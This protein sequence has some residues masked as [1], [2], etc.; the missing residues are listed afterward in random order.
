MRE[1]CAEAIEKI[2]MSTLSGKCLAVD[3][4]IYM[5]KFEGRGKLMEGMFA[6]FAMFVQYNI[7][8]IWV[9]DGKPPP[10]KA[11]TIKLRKDEKQENN[12]RRKIL[13]SKIHISDEEKRE[14]NT[15]TRL[16]AT[17]SSNKSNAV[18]QLAESFGMRHYTPDGEADQAC[19]ALV[20]QGHAWACI[21]DDTDMFAYSCPRVIR[22]LHAESHQA[23][24]YSFGTILKTLDMTQN[25]F[26]QLCVMSG[27]DYN[28]D[29]NASPKDI[30]NKHKL[31]QTRGHAGDA[32]WGW[33]TDNEALKKAADMFNANKH[34]QLPQKNNLS[35]TNISHI[36]HTHNFIFI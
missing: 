16:C 17:I 14:L 19:A 11:H 24:I 5:Y 21:S 27:T 20:L 1:Q 15:L 23:H 9:F 8:A 32:L 35:R 30:W 10:E 2:H 31:Q 22:N 3:T 6:M 13:E 26:K 34:I 12:Q 7:D 25:A 28:A 33:N 4:S 36:M 18:R 29:Q